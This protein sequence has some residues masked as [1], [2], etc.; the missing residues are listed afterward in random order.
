MQSGMTGSGKD[1]PTRRDRAQVRFDTTLAG[2]AAQNL[3]HGK[4]ESCYF[5]L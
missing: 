4:G 5:G 2:L 3:P 1:T